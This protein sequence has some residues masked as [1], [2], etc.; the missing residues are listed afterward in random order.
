MKRAIWLAAFIITASGAWAGIPNKRA[1]VVLGQ[2]DFTRASPDFPDGAGFVQPLGVVVDTTSHRLFVMDASRA[3]YWSDYTSLANGGS[4]EV[5]LGQPDLFSIVGLGPGPNAL[6]FPYGGFVDDAGALW[7]IDGNYSRVLRFTPPFTAGKPPDLVLGQSAFNQGGHGTT[8]STFNQPQGATRDSTGHIWVSDSAN[9]RILRFSPPFST[10]MNADLVLGQADFVSGTANGAGAVAANTLNFPGSLAFD[11]AGN[12]W[13][14]DSVNHRLLR[15][16]APIASGASASLVLGQ[17]G[18]TTSSANRGGGPAANT[19]ARPSGLAVDGAG[20]VWVPDTSNNRILRYNTPISNGMNAGL[21]LGQTTFTAWTANRGGAVAANT[22]DQPAGLAL[23]D[24]GALWVADGSNHR[25]LRFAP[26]FSNGMNATRVLGQPDFTH[27]TTDLVDAKG[28]HNPWFVVVDHAHDR[29]FVSD[30]GNNRVLW[31]NSAANL[32]T[33]KPADGVIG[34]PD[35]NSNSNFPLNAGSLNYPLG[36]AVDSSGALW[37][38]DDINNRVLRFTPPFSAGMSADLV[39]GQP[40]FTSSAAV[41]A[42]PPTAAS[43]NVPYGVAIDT[44][45]AVFVADYS[46]GRILR[47]RAPFSSGMSADLVLGQANFTA[48]VALPLSASLIINP[49]GL[50]VDSTGVVWA[51]DQGANRV[52][53]YSPPLSDGKAADLVLGQPD[54]VTGAANPTPDSHSMIMPT[55]AAFDQAG[56]FWISDTSNNRMLQFVP[57]F[58]N[59]MAASSVLGQASL[60]ASDTAAG[61]DGLMEPS[62]L[63]IDAANALWVAD[64][65]NSRV[66]KFIGPDAVSLVGTSSSQTVQLDGTSSRFSLDVPAGAFQQNV[67]V[68]MSVPAYVPPS[69]SGVKCSS[70]VVQITNDLGLQPLKPL[71]LTISYHDADVA[72]LDVSKLG[73]AYYNP[74]SGRWVNVPSSADTVNRT[75]TGHLPH[76]TLFAIVQLSAAADLSGVYTYP[77][78]YKPG[79]GTIFDDTAFGPGIVFSGLAARNRI[80]IVTMAGEA[81]ADFTAEDGLGRYVWNARNSRGQQVAS[82][83]YLYVVTSLDDKSQNRTGR[84]SIIR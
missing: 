38:G 23:D 32:V 58:S 57:P 6:N 48:Q 13:V 24:G 61:E 67:N 4:A 56:A 53:R 21:V 70:V 84:F 30:A 39:L 51:V 73:V 35:F 82:G 83:V 81:V 29:A 11:A 46:N 33:G 8:A 63:F 7:V 2:M 16:N 74:S 71:T 69:Q 65:A 1:N 47:Y 9:H 20:N 77:N 64:N 37:V 5:S 79:S 44:T 14:A 3:L 68:S 49:A 76:L 75:V 42:S 31:W 80:R 45:G 18:F 41:A 59:G 40:N 22:L 36:L 43:L 28:F 78:P 50:L 55:G 15:F 72:G 10:G 26:A 25:V 60:T 52:L 62:G 19:L 12:L 17:A 27:N 34:Q 66:L 54:F